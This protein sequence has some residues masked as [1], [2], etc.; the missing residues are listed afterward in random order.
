VLVLGVLPPATA[1]PCGAPHPNNATGSKLLGPWL[2]VAGAAQ[3]PQHLLELLLI[4]HGHLDVRPRAGEQELSVTQRV[5]VGDQCLTN[6]S[7]YFRVSA[8]NATLVKHAKTHQ[9]LGMLMNLSSEDVLLIQYQLQRDRT[10]VGLY[11]YAR[12]LNVSTDQQEEFQQLASSTYPS[13]LFWKELCQMK[14]MEEGNSPC[15]E[16]AAAVTASPPP[17]THRPRSAGN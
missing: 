4:D 8:G 13:F 15:A 10:Y 3:F 6:N 14:D 7:T 17:G 9:T 1:F 2:Y 11:L 16:P 5:A 12:N